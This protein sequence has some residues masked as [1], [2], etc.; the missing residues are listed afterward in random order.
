MN[1]L[2]RLPTQFSFS[3]VTVD[4][5]GKNSKVLTTGDYF[6][7]VSLLLQVPRSANVTA[8]GQV[9]CARLDN[10]RFERVFAPAM[11]VLKEGISQYQGIHF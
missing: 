4:G 5:F 6:G 1:H 8:R 2:L 9:R 11:D 10:V 3:E 7:E